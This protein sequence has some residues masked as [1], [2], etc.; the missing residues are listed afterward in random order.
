MWSRQSRVKIQRELIS[1]LTL[2]MC[3]E[4]LHQT[5]G[6]LPATRTPHNR[7]RFA[8]AGSYGSTALRVMCLQSRSSNPPS[9]PPVVS[10]SLGMPGLFL[11]FFWSGD[12]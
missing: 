12:G 10:A 11:L 1:T 2:L 6:T 4:H 3:Q 8:L 5:L 7:T 9:Q